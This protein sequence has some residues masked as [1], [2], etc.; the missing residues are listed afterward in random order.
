MEG[1]FQQHRR[2]AAIMFTDMVGYSALAQKDEALSLE[3]LNE[4]RK[5]LRET[6][7]R[8][9]GREIDANARAQTS[10]RAV[11][12]LRPHPGRHAGLLVIRRSQ[13]SRY[14][15]IIVSPCRRVARLTP[16]L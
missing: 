5:L 13:Q 8:H 14:Q 16:E 12:R 15:S 7:A 11:A 10:K 9:G 6:F 3:L 1:E 2:L 4:Q